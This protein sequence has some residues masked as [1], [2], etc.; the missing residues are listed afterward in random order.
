M[1]DEIKDAIEW[2]LDIAGLINLV[3]VAYKWVKEKLRDR[4]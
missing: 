3:Y 1:L 4:R 2:V